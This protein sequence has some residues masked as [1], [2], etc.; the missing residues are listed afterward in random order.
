MCAGSSSRRAEES[1]AEAALPAGAHQAPRKLHKL[2]E[3]HGP[4][5]RHEPERRAP[6]GRGERRGAEE[7]GDVDPVL[8]IEAGGPGCGLDSVALRRTGEMRSRDF[9]RYPSAVRWLRGGGCQGKAHL[10]ARRERADVPSFCGVVP[11]GAAP[12][13]RRG[14]N[15]NGEALQR[16]GCAGEHPRRRRRAGRARVA[17]RGR[18][19][20]S[21]CG[22]W[23]REARLGVGR[24][25]RKSVV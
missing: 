17:L 14:R 5:R 23:R 8:E 21:C 9:Q 15:S 3:L 12:A 1:D 7:H 4:H 13:T 11:Q 6:R 16:R 2:P 24:A 19:C 25:D 10:E 18:P 20:A 22:P